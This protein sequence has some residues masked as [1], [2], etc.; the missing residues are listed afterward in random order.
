MCSNFG[1]KFRCVQKILCLKLRLSFYGGAKEFPGTK[2]PAKIINSYL[3][4]RV[5]IYETEQ[6]TSLRGVAAGAVH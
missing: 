6:G 2:I 5:I 4:D 3:N 1:I